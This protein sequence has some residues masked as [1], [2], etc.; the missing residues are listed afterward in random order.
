M[1]DLQTD[2]RTEMK[3]MSVIEMPTATDKPE[4]ELEN[5]ISPFSRTV[6]FSAPIIHAYMQRVGCSSRSLYLH[7][8]YPEIIVSLDRSMLCGF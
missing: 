7:R 5:T 2:A 8:F 4:S 1:T 6:Q 3:M